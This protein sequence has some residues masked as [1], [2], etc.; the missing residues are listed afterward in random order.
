MTRI[1]RV[2]AVANVAS[3]GVSEDAPQLIEKIFADHGVEANVCAPS[4]DD[5]T[6]CLRAA[7]DAAP[8]LL[9]VLAGDGTARAAAEMCGPD[10]PMLAP[11]AG[12]TMNMLPHAVYGVRPWQDALSIALAQGEERM[13]GG[14][15]VE[16][17]QFLVAGIFGA[18]ALW[19]P[20]REA[21]RYGKPRLAILRARRAMRRAFNG[22]LRYSLDGGGREKAEALTFMCPLASRAL[23]EDEQV[24]EAAA[25]D[26]NGAMDAFRLGFHALTGDW[27][28]DPGV[29][30]ERCRVAQIWAQHGIP[31]ILDGESVRLKALAEVRWRSD[32]VRVL[33]IPKD[34]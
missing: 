19:A 11:L 1:R 22:R 9:V 13:L 5:L 16:G 6:N 8:D 33:G 28:D 10:G 14:G 21:A 29:N 20:A 3:G 2:E 25:L 15:E 30:A 7:V 27:R 31:A 17:R 23:S 12:G 4:T 32:I 34:L 24:L 18:P 26:L